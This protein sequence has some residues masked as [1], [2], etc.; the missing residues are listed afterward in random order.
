MAIAK[1]N[2]PRMVSRWERKD[3]DFCYLYMILSV[4]DKGNQKRGF[5]YYGTGTNDSI[6]CPGSDETNS[7]GSIGSNAQTAPSFHINCVHRPLI[8]DNHLVTPP[9]PDKHSEVH[10]P[11]EEAQTH[12]YGDKADVL[13]SVHYPECRQANNN[14]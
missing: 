12:Q 6:L 9:L 4:A 14:D 11:E 5:R 1:V 3:P 2:I 10:N 8:R 13:P 7:P